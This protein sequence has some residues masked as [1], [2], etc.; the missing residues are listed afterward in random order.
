MT[1]DPKEAARLVM[2]LREDDAT[3]S[4]STSIDMAA[5][6]RLRNNAR[7]IADQL[8][9]AMKEAD[10]RK[11]E[12]DVLAECAM[13]SQ[14]ERDRAVAEVKRM[15]PIMEVVERVVVKH[16]DGWH[17]SDDDIA[18]VVNAFRARRP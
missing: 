15:R 16:D 9:A 6:A 7:P 18:D 4:E 2:E 1:F 5:I 8:E 10:F 17:V 14:S 13:V 11:R 3:L 12:A